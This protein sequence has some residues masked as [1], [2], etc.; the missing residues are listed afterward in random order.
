LIGHVAD[1]ARDPA[2]PF[3]WYD[4]AVICK[5]IAGPLGFSGPDKAS[6]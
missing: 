1:L 6:K 5:H 4:A 3:D 2:V